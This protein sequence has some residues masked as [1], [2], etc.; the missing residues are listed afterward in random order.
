MEK[1]REAP[2]KIKSRTTRG[3]TNLTSG[4]I[5]KEIRRGYGRDNCSPTFS[6]ALFT[7][8]KIRKQPKHPLM[9]KVVAYIQ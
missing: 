8:A 6:A 7:I 5:S 1:N 9:D 3:S 2:P 4:S